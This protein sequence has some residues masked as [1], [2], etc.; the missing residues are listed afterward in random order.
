MGGL[1][2]VLVV[3]QGH[4]EFYD[5]AA[6]LVHCLLPLRADEI[7]GNNATRMTLYLLSI[8]ANYTVCT[9]SLFP[10]ARS[11]LETLDAILV[12]RGGDLARRPFQYLVRLGNADNYIADSCIH[13]FAGVVVW[14]F[15]KMPLCTCYFL[16]RSTFIFLT[17][18]FGGMVISMALD[19]LWL[20]LGITDK[21][22]ALQYMTYEEYQDE[23][24]WGFYQIVPILL[25]AA[26]VWSVWLAWI[27]ATSQPQLSCTQG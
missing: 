27:T 14:I 26:L 5:N 13:F 12:P 23:H 11:R 25:V 16:V 8:F 4:H 22:W 2:V 20:S 17:E 10:D 21:E 6:T 3:G 15:L 7:K 1:L 18:L 19:V 9:I 24:K